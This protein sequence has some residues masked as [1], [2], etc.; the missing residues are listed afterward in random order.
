MSVRDKRPAIKAI[1]IVPGILFYP[2]FHLARSEA[3]LRE[4]LWGKKTGKV[5]SF[6]KTG[7]QDVMVKREFPQFGSGVAKP[8]EDHETGIKIFAD[9]LVEDGLIDADRSI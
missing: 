1:D 7:L 5:M 9:S 6:K 3:G 4:K 2:V 8:V